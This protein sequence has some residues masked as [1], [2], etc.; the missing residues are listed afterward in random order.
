MRSNPGHRLARETGAMG[1]TCP[2]YLVLTA[3]CASPEHTGIIYVNV[4]V[5]R[6]TGVSYVTCGGLHAS[7]L[8]SG[9]F[10]GVPI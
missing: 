2:I 1:S 4:R 6:M 7:D 3:S 8:G 5:A 10:K 9:S